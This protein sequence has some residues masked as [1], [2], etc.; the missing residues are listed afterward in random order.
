[1]HQFHPVAHL[2]HRNGG[3]VY[4]IAILPFV[5][6][7]VVE[8]S[9]DPIIGPTPEEI[10]EH[11]RPVTEWILSEIE[12]SGCPPQR[13]TPEHAARL[14]ELP[15]TWRFGG[16]NLMVGR[17]H[18]G[19]GEWPQPL[20]IYNWSPDVWWWWTDYPVSDEHVRQILEDHGYYR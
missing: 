8:L 11:C 20:Y 6:W 3:I 15:Y 9:R 2:L 10:Q 18:A 19:G 14:D 4:A 16:G 5:V 7:L 12:R 13:I 1:V 17:L